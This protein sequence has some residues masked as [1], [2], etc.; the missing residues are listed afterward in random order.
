MIRDET[1]WLVQKVVKNADKKLLTS[2]VGDAEK[3]F[4]FA[5]S[6]EEIH[7]IFI[8]KMHPESSQSEISIV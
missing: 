8:L 4:C 1:N 2:M 6:S 3:A 7:I 5:T